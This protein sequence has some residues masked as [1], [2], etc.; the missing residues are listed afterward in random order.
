VIV[1]KKIIYAA[2]ITSVL[3]VGVLAYGAD[4]EIIPLEE[5]NSNPL[6][7]I[8]KIDL[9]NKLDSVNKSDLS[10]YLHFTAQQ[11]IRGQWKLGFY[12]P[13]T[14]KKMGWMN[15]NQ[16]LLICEENRPGQYDNCSPLKYDENTTTGAPSSYDTSAGWTTVFSVDRTSPYKILRRYKNYVIQAL[17]NNLGLA[18]NYASY[19]QSFF[20]IIDNKVTDIAPTTANKYWVSNYN[21]NQIDAENNA[22]TLKNWNSSLADN[23]SL[24][25]IPSPVS[26]TVGNT[27]PYL[28]Q[29]GL[30]IHNEM[31]LSP[32]VV[33]FFK[34]NLAKDIGVNATIDNNHNETGI[35]I[36][37]IDPN[38]INNNLEGYRMTV[39]ANSIIIEV[40]NPAGAFYALQTLRQLWLQN[41][42]INSMT[43][44]DYPRFKYR[45]LGVDSARHFVPVPK[46]KTIIDLMALQKL[47]TL[48]LRIG[49]DEGWRLLLPGYPTLKTLGAK[50]GYG[51]TLGQNTIAA[52]LIKQAN[53][54]LISGLNRPELYAKATDFYVGQYTKDDIAELIRYANARQVT[55]I[56][57]IDV[58]GH[59]RAMVRSLPAA[60]FDPNDHSSFA[61]IQG[62]SDNVIPICTY[63]TAVSIGAK[64]TGTINDLVNQIANIFNKQT[65]LYA[66]DKEVSLGG[67]EVSGDA[68]KRSASCNQ[69]LWADLS[70]LD[71]AQYFFQLFSAA[72]PTIK[73]SG[74]QQL[75]QTDETDMGE[76]AV[77][78][79]NVGHVWV[80]NSAEPG[81]PQAASLAD[82]NY[83]T[84]LAFS[85]QLYFDLTY[86]KDKTEL[87]QYWATSFSDTQAALSAAA[88]ASASVARTS[89]P[90]KIEGLEGE[91][92][93]EN[94]VTFGN[95]A[96]MATPKIAG[97]AE[98]S[99]APEHVTVNGKLVNWQSLARRLGCGENGLLAMI[100]KLYGIEYRGYPHGIRKEVP[101][102]RLCN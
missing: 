82:H 14:F 20:I 77:P 37:Q 73:L 42:T 99:W 65:T 79:T 38:L 71:K 31:G 41:S 15:P 95:I 35:I 89:K 88:S 43:V 69:G 46:L 94:M 58:P 56:P 60:F 29:N 76:H 54:D 11:N 36:R 24:N 44:V 75:V 17:H 47:N 22:H 39:S 78:A 3:T 97:L 72:N 52:Q 91:L 16:I 85:D 32:T 70:A 30:T 67:D 6:I 49:D 2:L 87:G 98:A 80:W 25:V 62:F 12:M 21:Q 84:V 48:H 19:P 59:A 1:I 50:R 57:E 26:Y 23:N 5:S 27:G 64:F 10:V 8:N 9:I 90:A 40:T 28:L 18:R 66:I 7:T 53:L 61:S 93:G 83:P 33:E 63:N 13:F 92:W 101:A 96:Y 55:V 100:N 102:G 4:S 34:E 68:W 86:N 45:G 81:I 74:W 51:F